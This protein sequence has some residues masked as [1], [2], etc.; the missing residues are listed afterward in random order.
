[1][2]DRKTFSSDIGITLSVCLFFLSSVSISSALE[3]M[4]GSELSGIDGGAGLTMTFDDVM[5]KANGSGLRYQ[6]DITGAGG[7]GY[8]EM[9]GLKL[10]DGNIFD[11]ISS[12]DGAWNLYAT[13]KG[14]VFTSG[15]IPQHYEY[16]QTANPY[17]LGLPS[18][19]VTHQ[20]VPVSRK[21]VI[22]F[23]STPLLDINLDID[24][25]IMKGNNRSDTFNLGS[26]YIKD[27]DIRNLRGYMT[28]GGGIRA[29]LRGQIH[30]GELGIGTQNNQ[31]NTGLVFQGIN[32]AEKFY[33]KSIN[34]GGIPATGY[35]LGQDLPG[36][37]KFC[38]GYWVYG[39][40]YIDSAVRYTADPTDNLYHLYD[41]GNGVIKVR[42]WAGDDEDSSYT[43]TNTTLRTTDWVG[44]GDIAIGDLVKKFAGYDIKDSDPNSREQPSLMRNSIEAG[45]VN[46]YQSP[47]KIDSYTSGG[48]TKVAMTLNLNASVRIDNM[49]FGERNSGPVAIDGA[50]LNYL[51][52]RL[53]TS[54]DLPPVIVKN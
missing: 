1:M 49:R 26:V 19:C 14:D 11:S 46:T 9:N 22:N 33:N 47:I 54:P 21:S 16:F 5:I 52:L 37:G 20:L 32:L 38:S 41:M 4:S 10:G 44:V 18:A 23:T 35:K 40:T 25:I 28:G 31:P 27:L 43:E 15:D 2:Q 30:I 8:I 45:I 6:A 51:S 13:I 36:F 17:S 39:L 12:N 29:A 42:Q 53:Q 50:R 24:D 3:K 48:V 34:P 7:T